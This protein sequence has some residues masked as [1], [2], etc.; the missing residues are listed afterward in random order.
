MSAPEPNPAVAEIQGLYGPFTFSEKLLQ[1]IWALGGFDQAAI[2]TESGGRIELLSPGKWN[3]LAG[4]DFRHARWRWGDGPVVT[5]D[6]ELHLRAE[7]WHAHGHVNDRTYDG[8]KLHVVLFP[9]KP[10]TVTIGSNG[11]PIPILALLPYLRHDLEEYAADE[12]VANLANYSEIRLLEL[13]Q[14]TDPEELSGQWLAAAVHRWH[15]KR[16]FAEIRIGKLGWVEACHQTAMEILG[17]RYNRV[18]MLNLAG[19]HSLNEWRADGRLTADGLMREEGGHWARSGVRPANA[20]K[21]RLQQYLDWVSNV[22]DWPQRLLNLG[23]DI[24]VASSAGSTRQVR[25]DLGLRGWRMR[26]GAQLCAESVGGTRLD[27]MICDGFLPLLSAQIG[28][29]LQGF[30]YHWYPGDMPQS[31]NLVLRQT[32]CSGS[33]R[34]TFC[35]GVV[36]GLIGWLLAREATGRSVGS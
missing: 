22:P 20:P 27:T 7:D 32:D 36:Q 29:D 35:H 30:W 31:L 25:R 23:T 4:P 5:G 28:A 14:G 2:R 3:L 24:P 1:K 10:G 26:F 12:A 11:Q 8:V 6:V 9:P 19:R 17:Y 18:P 16:R 33:E 13:V 21:R 34:A 15:Q